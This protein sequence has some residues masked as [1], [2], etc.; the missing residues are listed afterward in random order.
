[1]GAVLFPRGTANEKHRVEGRRWLPG[2]RE[3][4]GA[5]VRPR[6]VLRGFPPEQPSQGLASSEGGHGTGGTPPASSEGRGAFCKPLRLC[7]QTSVPVSEWGK[8]GPQVRDGLPLSSAPGRCASLVS[9]FLFFKS[10]L[11]KGSVIKREK[12]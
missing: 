12:R 3:A 4:R 11:L 2:L 10:Y 1:M 7:R 6:R 8:G 9:F 5:L